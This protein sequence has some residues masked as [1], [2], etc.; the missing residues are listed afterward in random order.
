M[1]EDDKEQKEAK[2][3][4][5]A[6]LFESYGSK[7][8]E[9]VEVGA[10][11][12]GE[13][14][15]IGKESVF[16]DIGAKSDAVV[17]RSEL[18][19]E[20]GAVPFK[21]GDTLELY[22]VSLTDS[23]IRLSKAISRA[24]EPRLLLDAFD[25]GIPVEGKVKGMVKGGFNVELMHRRA[26]CPLGQI[27]LHFVEDPQAYIGNT[28][29]F[30]ITQFEEDGRNLVVSRREHLNRELKE[31]RDKFLREITVGAEREGRVKRMLAY[32]AFVELFPG[33]EGMVHISELSWS[34]LNK[35]EE[36]LTVG[37]TVRV[38]I[39]GIDKGDRPEAV[40]IT[41]SIKQLSADP[42]DTVGEKLREGDKAT[43][44]V[45]RCA[46][47]GAFVELAPGIEGL[48]HISE[49]SYKKR[50]LKPQDVVGVGDVVSVVVKEIDPEKRR[51]TLAPG[52]PGAEGH[53]RSFAGDSG[54]PLGSLGER[55]QQALKSKK[56]R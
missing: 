19:D 27:D 3:E 2:E 15:S 54:K 24:G 38:K 22:V 28:Y 35:P 50:V 40:R 48:V 5:F 45:T 17:E 29:Y 23:E 13:I 21:E 47:F 33:I 49:M 1:S 4:G 56:K 7:A 20:K 53:W 43:G 8:L 34:R 6:E 11:V 32:G 46:E 26:F 9:D 51:I 30:L 52:D 10:K 36:V 44:T 14:I 41:L 18:L 31:E 25:K 42:W 12:K 37:D 16:V 55:F 39:I